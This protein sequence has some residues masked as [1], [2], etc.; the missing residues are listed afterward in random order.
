MIIRTEHSSSVNIDKS[1][2]FNK[3]LSAEARLLLIMILTHDDDH[4][5]KLEE[6]VKES[7]LTKYKTDKA[8]KELKENKYLQYKPILV[9]GRYDGV[10]W[11]IKENPNGKTKSVKKEAVQEDDTPITVEVISAEQFNFEQFWNKYPKK[12]NRDAA[13]KAF[14]SIPDVNTVFSDIMSALD[15]QIRSKQWREEGGRYIPNPENYLKKSSW[16]ISVS[17]YSDEELAKFVEGLMK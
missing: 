15:I 16:N 6:L 14:L 3:K 9:A 5:F 11:I 2:I 4:R 17:Q 8:L 7:G 10:E 13:L 12:V 1:L